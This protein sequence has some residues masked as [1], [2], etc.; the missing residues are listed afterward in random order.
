M[1]CFDFDNTI[2]MSVLGRDL[3]SGAPVSC[4][5]LSDPM[6]YL[7][8]ALTRERTVYI[9]ADALAARRAAEGIAALSDKK[10]VLMPAKD[11]VLFYRKA[12]SKDAFYQ[13]L[14]AIYEWQRGA[15]VL[16]GDIEA[17]LGLYPKSLPVFSL[18]T[19][20]EQDM[21][22]LAEK[23]VLAGYARVYNVESKG[24]FA[25][26]GDI[27]DIYPINCEHPVRI[28]FFGDEIE[29]IKPYDE[30]TGE[31]LPVVAA[32]EIAAATDVV[33]GKQL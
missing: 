18:R 31:R 17:F 19:G 30:V 7:A 9:T 16:V 29:S 27:L 23:L 4:C 28:D 8:A 26:R 12:L 10:V 14:N 5:G 11:E 20:Q 25:L 21:R 6:K 22:S 15:D 3:Q 1:N 24:S 32:I 33:V 13:R 2:E